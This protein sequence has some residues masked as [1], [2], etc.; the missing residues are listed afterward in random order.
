MWQNY[1]LTVL[2]ILN[3]NS[4]DAALSTLEVI[5]STLEAILST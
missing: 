5:L 2:K 1:A 4:L 3:F